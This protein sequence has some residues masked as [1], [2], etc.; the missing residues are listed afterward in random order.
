MVFFGGLAR[1][2]DKNTALFPWKS[3]QS[4]IHQEI[5]FTLQLVFR[6]WDIRR[7][8]DTQEVFVDTETNQSLIVDLLD[9]TTVVTIAVRKLFNTSTTFALAMVFDLRLGFLQFIRNGGC[10]GLKITAENSKHRGSLSGAQIALSD[11]EVYETI[12]CQNQ[13]IA[14]HGE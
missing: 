9:S 3:L 5:R 14:R 6:R 1:P 10:F 12:N 8:S 13:L 7:I 11:D 2:N 4:T